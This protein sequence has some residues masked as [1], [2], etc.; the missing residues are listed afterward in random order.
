MKISD[1]HKTLGEYL[2]YYGDG[3]VF[4][5]Y[6]KKYYNIRSIAGAGIFPEIDIEI[7]DCVMD[8][9]KE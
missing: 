8:Y 4:I 7:G 5:F 3:D 1:L 9:S 2:E 6:K